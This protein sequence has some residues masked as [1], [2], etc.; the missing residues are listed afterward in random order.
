MSVGGFGIKEGSGGGGFFEAKKLSILKSNKV[1]CGS[2]VH[3]QTS[4]SLQRYASE[5]LGAVF[6]V[7]FL[8]FEQKGVC[9]RAHKGSSES[10][11]NSNNFQRIH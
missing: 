8:E 2:R 1:C 9:Y 3:F 6:W 5:K 7:T 10:V 4:C 11:I